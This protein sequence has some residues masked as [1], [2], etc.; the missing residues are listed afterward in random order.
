MNTALIVGL[1]VVGLL[2]AIILGI[3]A[4]FNAHVRAVSSGVAVAL[5]LLSVLALLWG[6][7][8]IFR[9][10]APVPDDVLLFRSNS[11]SVYALTARDASVRWTVPLSQLSGSPV[12][13]DGV[14]YVSTAGGVY[15]VRASDGHK[16]WHGTTAI[17]VQPGSI[18]Q[19]VLYGSSVLAGIDTHLAALNVAD[20]HQLWQIAASTN[21]V[22]NLL[23]VS[24]VVLVGDGRGTVHALDPTSGAQRWQVAFQAG[25]VL[26]LT[27]A[28]DGTVYGTTQQFGPQQPALAF[29]LDPQTHTVRWTHT[30]SASSFSLLP[31]LTVADGALYVGT[32]TSLVALDTSLGSQRWSYPLTNGTGSSQVVVDQGIAYFGN[33]GGFYALHSS[34]G[35]VAWKHSDSNSLAFGTPLIVDGVVFTQTTFA[36]PENFFTLDSGMHVYAFRASD[37]QQYYRH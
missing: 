19:G 34:D 26:W 27:V 33:V 7:G 17:Q 18:A 5:C 28:A 14:V 12:A 6:L 10:T 31:V 25:P 15:A 20:G 8:I 2:I 4:L 37:G 36:G 22:S 29:A 9:T 13:Q 1:A 35:S 30:F 11:T 21:Q 32:E 24:G 23:P 16:L 3:V